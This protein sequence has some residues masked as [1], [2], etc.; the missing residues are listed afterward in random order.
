MNCGATATPL[1]RRDRTG[2]YLCNACGL[3]HKMNGQNR[4]LI[5]PKKRLVRPRPASTAVLTLCRDSSPHALQEPTSPTPSPSTKEASFVWDRLSS[6]Y[7]HSL[8]AGTPSSPCT[9]VFILGFTLGSPWGT[10]KPLG[11]GALPTCI[12]LIGLGCR[13]GIRTVSNSPSDFSGWPKLGTT[14]VFPHIISKTPIPARKSCPHPHRTPSPRPV[15]N[16]A[17]T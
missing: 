9:A 5:R 17:L 3:Y 2:H 4:P 14:G 6:T 7:P 11:P 15:R 16:P 8:Q 1:W 10:S 13:L 12:G